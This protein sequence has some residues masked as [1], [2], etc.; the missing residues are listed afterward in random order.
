M[1]VATQSKIS[2]SLTAC[3]TTIMHRAGMAGLYLTLKRLEEKY[4]DFRQ[5]EGNLSWS[6][7][8]DTIDLFWEAIDFSAL[9]WLL[10]ES[11]QLDDNGLI[12][13]TG[14][15]DYSELRQKIELNE[16]IKAV[17]LRHN[18]FYQAGEAKKISFTVEER[19]VSYSYKPLI[20]YA[21]QTFAK[22]LCDTDTQQLKQDYLQIT[23]WLYLG[24]IVRHARADKKTKLEEKPEYA[25]ALLFV[26][27]VC[28]YCL[29]HLPSEDVNSRKPHRYLVVIPEIN[30]FEDASRRRWR[31]QQLE[32]QQLHVTNMS[33]AGLLYYSLDEIQANENY[34]QAC[35]V[36]LY[37]KM[38]KASYQ[39]VL[40][41]V[42]EIEIDK[43]MITTYQQV[44]QYFQPNYQHIYP[45]NILIEVNLVRS[46][47]A[48]NL[49]QKQPWWF[50][51]WKKLI[52][53]DSKNY[54]FKQLLSNQKGVKFMTKN[55]E[56]DE[57]YLAFIEVFQQAMRANF[58]KIYAKT[59]RGK[60]PLFQKK[61]ERL[62][63]E[64][65][66]CYDEISFQH[67]LAD[68]LARG[69]LNKPLQG[70]KREVLLLIQQVP[71]E[72]LR[73]WALLGIASY[74]PKPKNLQELEGIKDES[75]EE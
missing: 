4:P 75:E 55:S 58:A 63:A 60:N 74:E 34:S 16:A 65:N 25:L 18:K 36:W 61:A 17:F 45:N 51:F 53:E 13:L 27:V 11:F 72:K 38:N 28:H 22:E 37:E 69:G 6:L 71:W 19:E 57:K 24:G 40:T 20:W 70:Q 52:D 9:D 1:T 5:R 73:I 39:R 46:L 42:E 35:Q 14:L 33:E 43:E 49:R 30:N 48:E 2:L 41:M 67:Y 47:I 15:D 29:F 54:L 68:F 32:P 23:S 56:R 26:P 7:T 3:D 21:H 64:L 62:R 31:L 44:K 66:C 50:N 10:K 8:P 59:E 12:C